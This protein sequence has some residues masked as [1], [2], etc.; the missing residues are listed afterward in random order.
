[1]NHMTAK[2]N[3]QQ[4]KP[5]DEL[6]I[7]RLE[8]LNV[9]DELIGWHSPPQKNEYALDLKHF[10]FRQML[11]NDGSRDRFMSAGAVPAPILGQGDSWA[12]LAAKQAAAP[13]R[14]SL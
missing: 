11:L 7:T 14:V 6:P 4:S 9:I 13:G 3:P 5:T 1:M 12:S 2:S 8:L 10:T